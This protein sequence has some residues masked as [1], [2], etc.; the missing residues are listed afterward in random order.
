MIRVFL[1]TCLA[2]YHSLEFLV[3]AGNILYV[4]IEPVTNSINKEDGNE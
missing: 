4:I 2:L 1:L 3:L